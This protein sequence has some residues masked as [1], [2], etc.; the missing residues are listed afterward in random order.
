MLKKLE[1]IRYIFKMFACLLCG[2]TRQLKGNS[3]ET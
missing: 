1:N 3:Q 2:M